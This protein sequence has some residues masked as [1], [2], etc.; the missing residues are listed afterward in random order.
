VALRATAEVTSMELTNKII[1]FLQ[2]EAPEEI[3]GLHLD[4]LSQMVENGIIRARSH[5]FTEDNAI[6]DFVQL[7]F[8]IAPNFDQNPA[9]A[10]A[11][12][13][14]SGVDQDVRAHSIL[15]RI[16]EEEW[17][18]AADS[19]DENAWGIPAGDE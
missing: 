9:F 14:T 15:E 3:E 5:G 19:Y 16:S 10:K 4:L 12:R 11:L 1:E 18:Q 13:E 17:N 2:N 7:M 6:Q 8:E